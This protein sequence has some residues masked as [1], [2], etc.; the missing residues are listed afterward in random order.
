MT[1]YTATAAQS[2]APAFQ[3]VTGT[4]TRVVKYTM[5]ASASVG[6]VVQMVKVPAGAVVADVRFGCSASAGAVSVIVGDGND[7]T[8]YAAA[9]VLSGSTTFSTMKF[10]GHG[11]SY[12]AE[13]TIDIQVTVISAP[14]E[15]IDLVLTVQYTMAN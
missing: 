14:P 7:K 15:T 3:N 6:D 11:R 10:I 4:I 2:T 5:P 8:A 12:S 9:T 13:D 1:T